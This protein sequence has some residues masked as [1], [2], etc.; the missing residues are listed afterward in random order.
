MAEPREL[1]SL[2]RLNR[3]PYRAYLLKKALRLVFHMGPRRAL[4]ELQRWQ[5]WA[6][7]SQLKPFVKL[8]RT[9]TACTATIEAALRYRISNALVESTNQAI[10]LIIRPSFG[11]NSSEA[12]I[13]LAKL[14]L[15]GLC[16]PL[17]DR[18]RSTQTAV[19]PAGAS[20]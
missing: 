18:S 16:P 10:G 20:R 13:A 7:R 3:P 19:V 11:F 17:R 9:I 2:A 1:D 12:I 14:C 4:K 5:F 8:A 15:G 6:R